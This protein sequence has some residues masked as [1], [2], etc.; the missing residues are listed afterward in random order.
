YR[1]PGQSDGEDACTHCKVS[2][3]AMTHAGPSRIICQRLCF[4]L[5]G[6]L[7]KSELQKVTESRVRTF[8]AFHQ[9]TYPYGSERCRHLIFRFVSCSMTRFYSS[10]C[11]L[12]SL[13]CYDKSRQKKC[14]KAPPR[15]QRTMLLR[16][17]LTKVSNSGPSCQP[18]ASPVSSELWRT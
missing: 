5:F 12:F 16:R 8:G 15:P 9:L 3:D 7:R 2:T 1:Y 13:H 11:M 10:F 14:P 17:S 6:S 4:T 18:S